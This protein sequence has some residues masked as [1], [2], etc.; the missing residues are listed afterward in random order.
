MP[1]VSLDHTT[2]P[3]RPELVYFTI[4]AEPDEALV[5][6]IRKVIKQK[7]KAPV[8]I[9]PLCRTMRGRHK[10]LLALRG[11]GLSG[12]HVRQ[13]GWAT[14][15]AVPADAPELQ[16]P[17]KAKPKSRGRSRSTQAQAAP[18]PPA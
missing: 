3:K 11:A 18:K 5:E 9:S 4:P 1:S 15:V 17:K 14:A 8:A 12:E 13:L 6:K 16:A 2:L 7:A 10:V